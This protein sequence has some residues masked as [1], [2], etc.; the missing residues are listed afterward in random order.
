MHLNKNALLIFLLWISSL[1]IAI[2]MHPS[3]FSAAGSNYKTKQQHIYEPLLHS[4]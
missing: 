3:D 2:F 1:I 4:A